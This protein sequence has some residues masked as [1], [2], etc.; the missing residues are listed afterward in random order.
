M[1][2]AIVRKTRIGGG[3]S[4]KFR[5]DEIYTGEGHENFAAERAGSINGATIT[6]GNG[7]TMVSFIE[8]PDSPKTKRYE[9]EGE[10]LT[11]TEIAAR[12]EMSPHVFYNRIYRL[13][14]VSLAI[15]LGK[16]QASTNGARF[17]K[18]MLASAREFGGE[19]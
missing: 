1:S 16:N 4:K 2:A 14:S 6:A 17:A 11:T 10:M 7:A 13:G 19:S 3:G 15:A 9:F 8:Q 5:V 18:L 12:L